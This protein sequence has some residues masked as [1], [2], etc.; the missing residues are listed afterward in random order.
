[1]K[2]P[3]R[4]IVLAIGVATVATLVSSLMSAS[5]ANAAGGTLG[6]D[7]SSYQGNVDWGAQ[8]AA[9][10]RF[11][12]I[13][14]TEGTYYTNAYFAQQYNGSAGAGLIRGAYH[15]ATPNTT[16]GATQADFFVNNGGGWSP[17]GITLPGAL[18]IEYNPYGD[19]CYDLSQGDMVNWISAFVNEYANRTGRWPVIYS[20]TD[21]WSTC[22]GNSSAFWGNDPL[23]LAAY[24][25]DPGSL[26]AGAP[27]W[28]FWQ[29]ADSGS[30][31]G[32]ND[33]WNGDTSSLHNMACAGEC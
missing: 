8:Y 29:F 17:D 6:Q 20:T 21:W 16:D 33:Y 15:F 30:L 31:A 11:A 24:S 10:S 18:D 4:R 27:Y 1:M 14:A 5:P 25:S 3:Y 23:W 9:G 26:P 28:S 7:V 13:K 12:Y 19:E 22:T 32:D 2:I